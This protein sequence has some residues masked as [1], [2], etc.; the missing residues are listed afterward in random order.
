ME[1]LLNSQF[2]GQEAKVFTLWFLQENKIP[3]SEHGYIQSHRCTD[4]HASNFQTR[5]CSLSV[6]IHLGVL[7]GFESNLFNKAVLNHDFRIR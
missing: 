7:M 2:K 3:N 5:A 4:A 6:G 1:T